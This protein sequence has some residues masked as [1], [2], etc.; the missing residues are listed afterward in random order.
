MAVKADFD[1]NAKAME[2]NVDQLGL[3]EFNS[4]VAQS[5]DRSLIL[6]GV[7]KERHAKVSFASQPNMQTWAIAKTLGVR[8]GLRQA[9]LHDGHQLA[10]LAAAMTET[11]ALAIPELPGLA[12]DKLNQAA[13]SILFQE[14]LSIIATSHPTIPRLRAAE[15]LVLRSNEPGEGK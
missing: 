6:A 8:A 11:L 14:L 4:Q 3:I 15:I 9:C 10:R 12:D 1:R 13:S 7:T 5:I 2:L